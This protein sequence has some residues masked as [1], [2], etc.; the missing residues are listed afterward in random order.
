MPKR[1]FLY[2]AYFEILDG[3]SGTGIFA[4]AVGG[5]AEWAAQGTLTGV[6]RNACAATG[7]LGVV[8]MVVLGSG[9]RYKDDDFAET[10]L[11][12]GTAQ[13]AVYSLPKNP[14]GIAAAN[15]VV[16]ASV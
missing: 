15:L 3:L 9:A 12:K 8:V 11:T 16:S 7:G 2:F 13:R 10:G 4:G 5:G 6:N 1:K 14:S